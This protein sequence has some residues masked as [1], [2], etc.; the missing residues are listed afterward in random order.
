MGG[1]R[2]SKAE[3]RRLEETA[4]GKECASQHNRFLPTQEVTS[5]DAQDSTKDTSQR[6]GRNNLTLE[7][8]VWIVELTQERRIGEE[9][10]AAHAKGSACNL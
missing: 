4:N 7:C 6:V 5:E 3:R 2:M 8:A 9:T 10:T 1:T